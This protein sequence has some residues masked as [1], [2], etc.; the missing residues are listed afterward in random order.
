MRASSCR[1][2][3]A[4]WLQWI[5]NV[6]PASY[7]LEALQQ[8]GAH[9][10]LTGH[11]SARHRRRDG[12]RRAWRCAWPRR[13]CGDGRLAGRPPIRAQAP[14]PTARESDTRDRI[15]ASARELFAAQRD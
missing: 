10:E 4:D 6:L 8:V 7:A 12:V 13:P 2:A 9:T 3:D 14:R 5:S 11:R 1:G 15:L